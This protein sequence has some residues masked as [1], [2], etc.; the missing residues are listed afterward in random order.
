VIA[1]KPIHNPTRSALGEYLGKKEKESCVY[2]HVQYD[3]ESIKNAPSP[4]IVA[5]S[6]LISEIRGISSFL[7]CGS[8][9]RNVPETN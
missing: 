9:K 3:C 6:I 7:F 5:S 4:I 8:K 2:K 1:I